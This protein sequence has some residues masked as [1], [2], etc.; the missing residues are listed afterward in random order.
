MELR[1]FI[2]YLEKK[3]HLS[4]VEENKDGNLCF[5]NNSAELRDEFKEVFD[6]KDV[7]A[8]CNAFSS[9]K[10]M[11]WPATAADFWKAVRLGK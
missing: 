4:F 9:N 1:A 6:A 8:Y 10:E 7:Q 5:R 3:L 11:P 2:D